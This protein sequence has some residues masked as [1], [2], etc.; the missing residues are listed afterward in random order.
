MA[1]LINRRRRSK[2]EKKAESAQ[3]MEGPLRVEEITWGGLTW[4]NIESPTELETDYLAEKYHF[5]PLALDDCMSRKQLPKVDVYPGYLFFVFHFPFYDKAT[6]ISSK[7]QWSAFIAEDLIVT[8][9]TGELR[10]LNALFR[11]CQANEDAREEYFSNGSG[12][13]LY[14]ILDRAIDSYFPVLEKILDL[15]EKVEDSV[16][17]ENI[18][19]AKE[20][21]IIRRDVITQRAVMF[22]TRAIFIEMENKLKRFSKTD[23]TAYYNDLMD[24]I[25]K[26]CE[27]LDEVQDIIEV[28][29][30][31]DYTLATYRINR[32]TRLLTIF[33][34]IILPFL[35]VSSLFGM[36]VS[37]P[38]G[39]D[40][41]EPVT[42]VILLVIMGLIAGGMLI[43]FRHRRWI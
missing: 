2:G 5:H 14:R 9:H 40:T 11:D 12:F 31:A 3:V 36:N 7:R 43:F 19:S 33:S 39:S 18:E 23:V 30:D 1:R 41:G 42:F 10:T 38:G 15:I 20:L 21:S 27:T 22:P 34:T 29:K 4:V 17:D 13:L 35:L 16:F 32:V 8:L 6:R 24:H 37:L 25:N 26:I 28:Y